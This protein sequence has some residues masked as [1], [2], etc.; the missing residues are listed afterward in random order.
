L[1]DLERS[2]A[3]NFVIALRGAQNHGFKALYTHLVD[4]S[5]LVKVYGQ[6]PLEVTADKISEYF[7]Y[8]SGARAFKSIHTRSLSAFVHGVVLNE[9][10]GGSAGVGGRGKRSG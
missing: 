3:D 9:G 4:E 7:K 2:G 6:G 10:P 5:Q 1:E 8:D